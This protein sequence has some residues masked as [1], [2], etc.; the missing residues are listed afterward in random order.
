MRFIF[1]VSYIVTMLAGPFIIRWLRAMKV[2]QMILEIGPE[3]HMKKQGTPT[4]GGIIFLLG[5]LA[6]AIPV[7]VTWP[8][9][10]MV[11]FMTVGFGLVG[12]IDDFMKVKK[13]ENE[14]LSPKQ[15]IILQLAV[16]IIFTIYLAKTGLGYWMYLPFRP[17]AVYIGGLLFVM[18]LPV[19]LGTVNGV[20]LTD[21]IDG[22]ATTVTI[23]AAFS[24]YLMAIL[25]GQEDLANGILCMAGAL[26]GF[27]RFNLNPAKVFMG[28]AGSLALGGFIAAVAYM[29]QAPLFI[30]M[31][32][33]IYLIES[34]SVIL[35]VL[36]FKA[37]KGKRLFKMSPLHHHYEKSGWSENKIV[38][39]FSL[40]N[41]LF[42][43]L[44]VFMYVY[45]G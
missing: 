10:W 19:V 41:M 28:D 38:I 8:D 16:V 17:D 29:L 13:K 30:L 20:N 4:M 42:G 36:Y 2:K 24:L 37:T 15:K 21:G 33:I 39:V 43:I 22:L 45:G 35:Q 44:G 34:V 3:W 6:G 9:F 14:G 32:G 26:I 7:A 5:F 12:F 18:V 25:T 1:I 23:I 31:L 11:I 40:I 27:L